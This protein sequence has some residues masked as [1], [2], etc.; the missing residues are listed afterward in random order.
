MQLPSV[1]PK[2]DAIR[3]P[4][5]QNCLCGPHHPGLSAQWEGGV[6]QEGGQDRGPFLQGGGMEGPSSLTLHDLDPIYFS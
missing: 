6:T 3:E 2:K 1:N 5:E 4:Y